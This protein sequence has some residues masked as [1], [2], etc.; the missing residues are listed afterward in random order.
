MTGIDLPADSTARGRPPVPRGPRVRLPASRGGLTWLIA[1]VVI[2]GLLAVQVGRQVYA[3]Y[4]ITQQAAALQR[5]ADAI[6]Q[7][8][9]RLQQQLAYL[10]STAYVD[11]AARRLSNVGR[12]GDRLLIIPPGAEVKLPAALQPPAPAPKPLLEQWLDLFFGP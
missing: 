12:A 5:E 7:Q 4:A 2:G 9:A 3:N 8:N 11:A 1:L 10:Q 6:A